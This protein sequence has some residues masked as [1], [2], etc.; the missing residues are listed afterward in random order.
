MPAG[1][2]R[3]G[4][5]PLQAAKDRLNTNS[6]LN[7]LTTYPAQS[8]APGAV[9]AVPSRWT[10]SPAK[11]VFDV[12]VVV[13]ILP[14]LIPALLAIALAVRI[15]SRGPVLFRQARV[16]RRGS[17]FPILKFRTMCHQEQACA[18]ACDD[19]PITPLGRWLRK[20]KLDE[21]P[22]FLN[23]LRGEMSLV[24]PRPKV[25][26]LEVA[27][28]PC[29]PGLTGA[30][31]LAFACE[32]RLFAEIPRDRLETYYRETVMPLKYQLDSAYMAD[33][34]FASDLSLIIATVLR[35]WRPATVTMR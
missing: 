17:T 5:A 28:P 27:P 21:L 34:T 12:A 32:E 1:F 3:L 9:S 31:T 18:I 35:R 24:G 4:N 33:A 10:Q 20:W 13:A 2:A 11:R 30:A 7:P 19:N 25:A 23:V 14:A 22:Q 6:L 15:T 8:V 26:D 16:G 29:R